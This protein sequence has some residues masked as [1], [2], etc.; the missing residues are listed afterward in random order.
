MFGL[1][2]IFIAGG[3]LALVYGGI[4]ILD[5]DQ[6]IRWQRRSATKHAGTARGDVGLMAQ[7]FLGDSDPTA[8][9]TAQ[10]RMRVRWTGTVLAI[11]GASLGG[12]GF[13]LVNS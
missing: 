1:G 8:E 12:L 3:V 2:L 7:R 11:L 10:L 6:A 4:E 13:V 5:P 9:P